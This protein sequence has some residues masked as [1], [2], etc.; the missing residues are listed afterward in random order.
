MK[1]ADLHMHSTVSDGSYTIEEL[2]REA[3][4]RGVDIIAVTDHDTLSQAGQIP[5]NLPVKVIPGIE[6][7]AY[8]YESGMK[9]HML[10][11][12][13]QDVEMVEE[14]TRP[15]LLA[16]HENSLRQIEILKKNGYSIR[17]EDLHRADG[18]YIYKQHIMEYL[19]RTGQAADMFGDFYKKTFKNGG[20]CD[21]D[22]HY[23]DPY[24]AV[25]V[26]R[27]AQGLAVLA[28]SGQQQNFS[29]IPKLVRAGLNGLE[30]NHPANSQA[31]RE[32][33]REYAK[34]YHLFLTGGS[35]FHGKY[36][37]TVSTIGCCLS[38]ESG[39]QAVCKEG[40]PT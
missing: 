28:H 39:T 1:K 37:N 32:I 18:T 4:A 14:F 35:D 20:I 17:E 21:F 12:Q 38:E 40:L 25:R 10:G 27:E 24:E 2:A 23:L 13:I 29:L 36:E 5:E 30:L 3:A 22:I 15:T 19:V 16:R 9:V 26:I 31:D 7:S 6:I 11:Y 34:E 8:D 33:I